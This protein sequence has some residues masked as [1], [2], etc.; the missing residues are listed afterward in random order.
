VTPRTPGT[1]FSS[2]G[3]S[4]PTFSASFTVPTLSPVTKPKPRVAATLADSARIIL[5][6]GSRTPSDH[7][8]TDDDPNMEYAR[9]RIKLD[10]MLLSK[11]G[12]T[13]GPSDDQFVQHL[14]TRLEDIK[15]HYF[16]HLKDAEA[17]YRSE[18][19]KAQ[20][21]GLQARLR[22][23]EVPQEA[24]AS[25]PSTPTPPPAPSPPLPAADDKDVLDNDG[26]EGGFFEILDEMPTVT[27]G[28]SGASIRVRA[29]PIPKSSATRLPRKF[30]A[31]VV[32]KA[33]AF[34]VVTF[35][36]ISGGSR[37]KR[38]AVAV[39]WSGGRAD[40]WVMD[41]VACHDSAEAEQYIATVAVHALT[42]P[43][44]EGFAGGGAPAAGQTFFRLLPPAFR[45]L[46]D[47]LEG[48][49]KA[50]EAAANRAVW[51]RLRSVVEAR[52]GTENKVRIFVCIDG[53]RAF[54]LF[55][56]SPWQ[57]V[58]DLLSTK[59]TTVLK[60]AELP[61]PSVILI[62]WK[63]SGRG[64]RHPLTR[65]CLYGDLRVPQLCG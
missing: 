48:H 46:W 61:I 30:L 35:R 25:K 4:T 9:L 16:F 52:T 18:R 42:Y 8:T 51:A 49:R 2:E 20:T 41:D 36:D 3:P 60:A 50:A 64:Y 26:S 19:Q 34:A 12:K 5:N 21:L 22:A 32:A 31:E 29:M 58:A 43:P 65:K 53:W 10:G 44:S 62:W 27:V 17:Q 57:R 54:T 45:E 63:H 38:A 1:P 13:A 59:G 28:E 23:N 56:A 47:E 55:L 33:D 37:A 39:R 15:T 7:D 24:A 14:R 6:D 40:E 11:R